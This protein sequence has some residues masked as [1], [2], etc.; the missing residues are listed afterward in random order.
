MSDRRILGDTQPFE[1]QL[2][3]DDGTAIDLLTAASV[4][5]YFRKWDATTYKVDGGACT[6]TDAENGKVTYPWA[7]TDVD[8]AGMYKYRFKITFTDGNILTVPS[9]D[10][11]WMYLIDPLWM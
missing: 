7:T 4:K 2:K 8:A 3:W 5:F 1:Y 10:V 6:I 9:N 11:L